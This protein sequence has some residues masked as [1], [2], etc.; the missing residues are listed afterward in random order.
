MGAVTGGIKVGIAKVAFLRPKPAF[1]PH[2]AAPRDAKSVEHFNIGVPRPPLFGLTPAGAN[3]SGRGCISPFG[4]ISQTEYE[5]SHII[6][7]IQFLK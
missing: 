1:E 5:N 2:A 6:V 3:E 7:L 4:A